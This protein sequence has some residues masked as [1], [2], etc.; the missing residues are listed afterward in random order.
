MSMDD[1][2]QA[3]RKPEKPKS[4]D[5]SWLSL[6]IF[7]TIIGIIA[8]LGGLGFFW[9]TQERPPAVISQVS[10]SAL[11]EPSPTTENVLGH[12]SYSEAPEEVL[13]PLTA[14]GGLRLRKSAAQE[15]RRMQ[16]DARA[17]GIILL[18]LSGFRTVAEQNYLFFKVKEQRNQ[19]AQK[20]AEVSAPP[21]YSEHH[22]GYALDIGDGRTPATNLS[23]SFE[24]TAAFHWLQQNAARYSF[25]MS[26]P[27]NN[28]QGI[29]YEPW[30]W[31]YVGDSTSLET[32]YKAQQLKKN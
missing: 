24:N 12:L 3:L 19:D 22:T 6:P 31:R 8:L 4:I 25:E 18:P 16:Q 17:D 20:R 26:F 32:F 27:L 30:H 21:G 1:I 11:V 10:P 2:P 13:V 9:A 5:D 28:P 7:A 29:N 23:Q 14:D 15:F